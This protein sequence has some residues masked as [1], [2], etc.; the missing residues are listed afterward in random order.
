M[1]EVNGSGADN[2]I[3]MPEES[4]II[5]KLIKKV[6]LVFAFGFLLSM[7]VLIF[8]IIMRHL[9]NAPTFWAHETTTFLCGIGFI[10]GGLYVTAQ[11]KHIRVVPVYE[12]VSPRIKKWLDILIYSVCAISTI[13]FSYAAWLMV[14]KSAFTP[15]GDLRLETSGS[16]WNPPTPA[17][18]KIFLFV[19]LIVMSIQFIIFAISHFRRSIKDD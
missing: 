14:E 11:N 13:F 10:F 19:I 16:A 6:S 1:D 8:E 3:Q 17:L 12:A 7:L 4:G 9:F 2:A 18:L 15:L 5:G